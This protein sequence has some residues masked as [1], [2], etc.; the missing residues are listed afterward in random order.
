MA[1]LARLTGGKVHD[2]SPLRCG[3]SL[4]GR[5]IPGILV[6]AF[7]EGIDAAINGAHEMVDCCLAVATEIDFDVIAEG[8]FDLTDA[9]QSYFRGEWI[10]LARTFVD[11]FD[12]CFE[13]MRRVEF[14]FIVRRGNDPIVLAIHGGVSSAYLG[15]VG[16]NCSTV[17]SPKSRQKSSTH[18]ILTLTN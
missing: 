9:V 15:H 8:V 17:M 6:T 7:D 14:C 18:G 12:S 13:P 10:F 2:T 5:I 1:Y 3:V 4:W 11:S 16:R